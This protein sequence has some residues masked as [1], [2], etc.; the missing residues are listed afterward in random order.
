MYAPDA[1]NSP[2]VQVSPS[3][4][5]LLK[6]TEELKNFVNSVDVVAVSLKMSFQ[7]A[8]FLSQIK[9]LS[10]HIST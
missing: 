9:F 3:L 1:Y 8:E 4:Q 6:N 10:W 7:T 2:A 5:M